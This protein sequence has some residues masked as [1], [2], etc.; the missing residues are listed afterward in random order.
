MVKG[1]PSLMEMAQSPLMLNV[2]VL[3]YKALAKNEIGLREDLVAQ[4]N[5]LFTHY[6][7]RMFRLAVV[8]RL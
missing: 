1:N 8:F 5:H 7:E 6:V 3:A 4:R 2:M